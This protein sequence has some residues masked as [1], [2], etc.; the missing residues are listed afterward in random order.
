MAEVKLTYARYGKDKV[1]VFRI[2]RGPTHH[3]VVEYTVCATLEGDIDVSYTQADNTVVIATDSCKNTVNVFAKKS[4]HVLSP[5]LFALE[6]GI[7]FVTKYAHIHK[8]HIDIIQHKWTRINVT[9]T[10]K[11]HPHSFVRDGDDKRLIGV[12]VDATKG[13]DAISATVKSGITDMLV[14][15]SSGSAFENFYTDEY[16]TLPDVSDRILSTSV[17]CSYT[18]TLP[19]QPL[20]LTRLDKLG[21]DFAAIATSVRNTTLDTFATDQSA[22]V[23]A[24]LYNMC[25]KII[26]DNKEVYDVS[27]K[28]PNKHYHAVNLD[29]MGLPNLKPAEAEVF[30][31]VESPSGLIMATVTR[32]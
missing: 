22:S 30:Q 12:I 28:L 31:P 20:T 11:A 32:A 4:A 27:Y 26:S 24:T 3:D 19:P 18:I 8:A 1:R 5:E 6:L 9:E 10:G 23:Q 21:I 2:V 15:K 29:F 25:K 16:R 13:T 7:H 17:D 14:L